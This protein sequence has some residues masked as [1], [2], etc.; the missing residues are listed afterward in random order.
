M[1]DVNPG[2]RPGIPQQQGKWDKNQKLQFHVFVRFQKDHWVEGAKV[3]LHGKVQC[4]GNIFKP[5][6]EQ[7][8]TSM[9]HPWCSAGQHS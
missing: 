6:S 5:T 3:V 4:N 9:W 8:G 2:L 7:P 1:L